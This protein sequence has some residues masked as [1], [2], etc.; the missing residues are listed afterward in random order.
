MYCVLCLYVKFFISLYVHLMT[1][2][3][4]SIAYLSCG[5][6]ITCMPTPNYTQYMYSDHLPYHITFHNM[7]LYVHMYIHPSASICHTWAQERTLKRPQAVLHVHPRE[8]TLN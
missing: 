7:H 2:Y 5:T 3:I 8:D 1:I 4:T 6:H